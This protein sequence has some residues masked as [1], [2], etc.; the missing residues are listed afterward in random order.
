VHI[1]QLVQVRARQ[2]PNPSYIDRCIMVTDYMY[3]HERDYRASEEEGGEMGRDDARVDTGD[4][5]QTMRA[6][7]RAYLCVTQRR[8]SASYELSGASLMVMS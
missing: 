4:G 8:T 1:R 2:R 6:H 3:R 7:G 5:E